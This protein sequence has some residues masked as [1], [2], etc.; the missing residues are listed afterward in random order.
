MTDQ[1]DP[2]KQTHVDTLHIATDEEIAA[3]AQ[4]LLARITRRA[5]VGNMN[6]DVTE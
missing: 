4:E 6:A 1:N 2:T 5:P 3:A